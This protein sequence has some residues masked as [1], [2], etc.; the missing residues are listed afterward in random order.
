MTE[1]LGPPGFADQVV[2]LKD[3]AVGFKFCA[4]LKRENEM[5]VTQTHKLS[6]IAVTRN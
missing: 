3:T 5:F 2:M 1:D 4:R 6:K